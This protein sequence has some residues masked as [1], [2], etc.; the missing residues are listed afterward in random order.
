MD[1]FVT[2]LTVQYPQQLWI[3]KG[4][5]ESEGIQCFLKDELTVQA[6]NLYS[7]AVGGVKLQVLQADVEKASAILKEL[8]YIKDEPVVA[9]LL[10][11]INSKTSKLPFLKRV[12]VVYGIIGITIVSVALLTTI[13]YL[14]LKPSLYDLLIRNKWCVNKIYYNNKLIGPKTNSFVTITDLNGQSDCIDQMSFDKN[15]EITL[16]GINSISVEGQWH[17][18]N[19]IVLTTGSLEQVFEGTYKV[20]FKDNILTLKS[21]TTTIYAYRDDYQIPLPF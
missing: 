10:T 13:L 18:G 4:R 8:G 19:D 20:E 21:A 15:H 7:N 17:E 12:N 6:Y 2:V 14:L 1:T 5:L 11:R 16:P 3:I 9:D